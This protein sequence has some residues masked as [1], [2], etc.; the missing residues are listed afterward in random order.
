MRFFSND[1]RESADEQAS[2]DRPERVQSEPVAVPG[3]RPPSPWSDAP[4]DVTRDVSTDDVRHAPDDDVRHAPDD[5]VRHATP[6]D[7]EVDRATDAVNDPDRTE[8]REPDPAPTAFGA[9]TVGGAVAASAATNPLVD[10]WRAT[11]RNADTGDRD[12]TVESPADAGTT[13]Y[14]GTTTEERDGTKSEEVDVALDDRGTFDDPHVTEQP[15]ETP[16]AETSAA[17]TPAEERKETAAVTPAQPDTFFAVGD[18]EAF[19]ER[20]RDVQLRFVDNPKEA[21]TEAAGL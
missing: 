10:R 20:W 8:I 4:A 12:G 19:Q 2:D 3:Q 17:G 11:D 1:A 14:A 21:T 9:S 7:D 6:G 13:T 18:A 5:D 15:A 16:V